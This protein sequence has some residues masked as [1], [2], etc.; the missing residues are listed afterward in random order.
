MTGE[1]IGDLKKWVMELARRGDEGETVRLDRAVELISKNFGVQAHEVAIMGL[2]SDE[3]SLRFLAPENLRTIG[4][5]PLSSGNSLATR[6]LREKRAEVIN[7]FTV[8]PHASVFEGVPVSEELRTPPI[9]KIMSS[10][11]MTGPRAIGV[12]QVSRKGATLADAG[13]DFTQSQLRELKI[14]S[15]A[16]APCILQCNKE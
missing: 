4:Q 10:P 15:D 6:T 3:R 8:V 12:L 2:T 1:H 13:A 14:I 9:Q 16:L 7:H 11:I 5:V